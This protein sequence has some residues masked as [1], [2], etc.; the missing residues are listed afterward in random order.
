VGIALGRNSS[1]GMKWLTASRQL[2]TPR[3][4]LI[5]LSWLVPM[6]LL[7]RACRQDEIARDPRID[8]LRD[9]MQC[10]EDRQFSRDYLD[11]NKRSIANGI[12]IEF[13]GG[14]QIKEVVVEYPVG[15]RRRREEAILSL[16]PS[17][18][19]TLPAGSLPDD[20]TRSLRYA[21]TKRSWK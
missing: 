15:H 18:E 19:P 9:K 3:R 5:S 13:Q 8:R 20:R 7:S 10:V 14:E 21:R 12:S 11:P 6:Q 1:P 2:S 16:K 17:S 4:I